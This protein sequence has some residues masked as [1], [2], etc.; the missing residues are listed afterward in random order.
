MGTVASDIINK[1]NTLTGENV[2][3]REVE[4]WHDGTAM[5]DS[6]CDGVVYKK[7]SGKYYA[8]CGFL[9][10]KAIAVQR[11]GVKGDDVSDDTA[12]LQKA[13]NSVAIINVSNA[14]IKVSGTVFIPS[15]KIITGV[16]S[17][18]RQSSDQTPMF[19]IDN[20]RDITVLGL[21]FLGKGT[22]FFNTPSS[23]GICFR[24]NK[25]SNVT[26]SNCRFIKFSYTPYLSAYST[27]SFNIKFINN[28]IEALQGDVL[29]HVTKNNCNGICVGADG[30]TITG[31]TFKYGAQ[32]IIIVERSKNIVISNNI[33]RD[34]VTE[35]GMYCDKELNNLCI[36]SNLV[37][38][39]HN[40]GIKVQLYDHAYNTSNVVIS[41]NIVDG[42]NLGDGISVT[43]TTGSAAVYYTHNV[44]ITG[45][46]C[47]NIGQDGISVR[48]GKECTIN[49][50]KVLNCNIADN[51]VNGAG[52]NGVVFQLGSDGV[53]I[54]GNRITNV[55]RNGVSSADSRSGIFTNDAQNISIQDNIVTSGETGNMPFAL[56]VN[57]T[58]TETLTIAGNTLVGATT[59]GLRLPSGVTSMKAYY[60]NRIRNTADSPVVYNPIAAI[61]AFAGADAAGLK[62]ELNA[63]LS[64]MRAFGLNI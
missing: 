58:N 19:N 21:T 47:R 28:Y 14:K 56:W 5:N 30:V 11:F 46:V 16:N 12:A 50:G 7:K 22:D 36:T 37:L 41:N 55:G 2:T 26:I 44:V 10:G 35:H 27:D 40:I 31:N 51:I 48:H 17:E 8:D 53:T 42:T 63:M 60:G 20:K 24:A 57:S 9:A 45:N 52:Y 49:F 23:L 39:C 54:T 25:S 64:K 15:G 32:G 29:D 18:I 1:I 43:N 62:T 61:P 33:I 4:S 3:Y 6:K 34:T 59:N 38:N 13:M